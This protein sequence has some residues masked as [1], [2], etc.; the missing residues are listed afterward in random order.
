MDLKSRLAQNPRTRAP[1]N[2]ILSRSSPLPVRFAFLFSI[3]FGEEAGPQPKQS[4]TETR[5]NVVFLVDAG[6]YCHLAVDVKLQ[7]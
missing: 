4:K 5:E 6:G 3:P 1:W 2:E 7:K